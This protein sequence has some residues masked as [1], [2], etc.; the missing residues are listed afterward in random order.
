[1]AQTVFHILVACLIGLA[2]VYLFVCI[3]R[4]RSA[5]KQQAEMQRMA[6]ENTA[7]IRENTE[8]LRELVAIN[9]TLLEQKEP[10][11]A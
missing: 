9:R 2:A 11:G 8:L 6:D 7:A 5:P 1:M 4:M 10:T 3:L